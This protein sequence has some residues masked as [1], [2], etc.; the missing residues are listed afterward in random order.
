MKASDFRF[1]WHREIL[2]I[3]EDECRRYTLYFDGKAINDIL[4]DISIVHGAKGI[5]DICIFMTYFTA[6]VSFRIAH[7]SYITHCGIDDVNASLRLFVH[8]L[9]H[10]F[11]SPESRKA[12]R[13]LCRCDPYM[14][15][16]NWFLNDFM[17]HPGDE[18]E[19]VQAIE[20]AI[21]VKNGIIT[22]GEALDQFPLSDPYGALI[23]KMH[24]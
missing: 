5:G 18:E 11:S 17:S 22:Y 21:A 9:C 2:P 12:C 8:A 19:F 20:M 4:S 23:D 6:N 16:V 3:L 7:G 10:G 24:S 14:S 1:L 13:D 15:R